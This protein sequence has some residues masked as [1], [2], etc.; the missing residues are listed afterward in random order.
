VS[1]RAATGLP[2]RRRALTEA[3]HRRRRTGLLV[4]IAGS[5]TVAGAWWIATGPLLAI[6]TVNVSGYRQPDQARVLRTV[7]I[8]ARD[9]TMLRLPTVAIR[10]ALATSPWVADIKVHHN[11]MRGIDVQIIPATPVAV[12]LTSSGERLVVSDTGRVL[13]PDTGRR[14]LPTFRT[15]S[16]TPG[17]WLRG[18]TQRAPF[19]VLIAMSPQ[20][21]RR[22][23]DL[24]IEGGVLVGSLVA[25][26]ALRL[27]PPRLLWAK[28]RALEAVLAN[29]KLAD[30]LSSAAY[31]DVSAPRQ[32]TLGGFP[33]DGESD[34]QTISTVSGSMEGSTEGQASP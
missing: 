28:G 32:P 18:A 24:R 33:A 25:G 20:T 15:V 4:V 34:G 10:D 7:Q 2:D 27:G 30:S 21:A 31:L 26:P 23:R 14:N 17:A 5:A 22:V 6:D 19:E 8:A 29:G 9:G 1:T 13:G 3:R 16:A 11:W 12:A